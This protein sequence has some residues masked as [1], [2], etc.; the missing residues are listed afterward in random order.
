[1]RFVVIVVGLMLSVSL[2]A[3]LDTKKMQMMVQKIK[4]PREDIS[5]A[6]IGNVASPFVEVE[7]IKVKEQMAMPKPSQKK[8]IVEQNI[9]LTPLNLKGTVNDEANINGEWLKSGEIIGEYKI[10]NVGDGKVRVQKGESV[11]ELSISE[12]RQIIRLR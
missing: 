3:D 11:Q 6:D 9:T 12:F 7:N 5:S 4:E 10:V 1:M 8:V 2:F